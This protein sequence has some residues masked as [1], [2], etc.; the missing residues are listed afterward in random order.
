LDDVLETTNQ[1]APIQQPKKNANLVPSQSMPIKYKED[2]KSENSTRSRMKE[3]ST[4]IGKGSKYTKYVELAEVDSH[5]EVIKDDD[6]LRHYENDIKLR[7]R[8]F[9]KWMQMFQDA[10]GGLMNI[11]R[12]YKKYG[13]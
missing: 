1:G 3:R 6:Y 12:G 2:N 13:L 8:E 11:A 7:I 9:N 10:E 4:L 5:L